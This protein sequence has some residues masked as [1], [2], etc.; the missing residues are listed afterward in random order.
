MELYHAA[1][2][3]CLRLYVANGGDAK[4]KWNIRPYPGTAAI[5]CH[6]PP[7]APPVFTLCMPSFPLNVRL[8]RWKS[9]LVAAYTVH[10]LLH[11]LWTDWGAV[12]QSTV[13]GLHG[14]TNALE[15]N[16]I[17]AR[18]SKGD[19]L[20]VS[21]A[22]KL[23]V[24]LNA[25]IAKRALSSTG[26]ALD[27]ASQFSFVLGLVIF[28]EKLAYPSELPVDWRARVKPEW[29]PLFDLAL[30]RFDALAST[31]DT[32]QLARDLKALA[33][34]LAKPAPKP[35]P[36][37]PPSNPVRLKIVST[38]SSESEGSM[39]HER[40]IVENED[41]APEPVTVAKPAPAGDAPKDAQKPAD[42]QDAPDAGEDSDDGED[43][44]TGEKDGLRGEDKDGFDA[45]DAPKPAKPE[46]A[47]PEP[48]TSDKPAGEPH[49]GAGDSAAQQDGPGGY[50]TGDVQEPVMP[51]PVEPAEDV[52]D[53]TQSYQEANLDD[54][55]RDAAK[56]AGL[57]EH[58]VQREAVQAST[59]L[60]VDAPRDLEVK[61]GGNPRRVGAAIASPAKLRR[62]LTL[63][64]KSPERV[65]VER[66]QV[67]GRLDMRNLVGIMTGSPTI[68]RRRIEEEGREAAVTLLLDISGS[69]A[70]GRLEAAKAL[71]LHMG[72]ALKAAGVRFEIAAFDD[73]F[74][75]TP[76]PFAKGWAN[77]T[78]RAVAGLSTLSGTGMLPAM[79]ACAERLLK[80]GNVSRRIL[81]ALTD[82]Q[83]SF[84][85][86]ANATLCRWYRQRGV[87]IVGIGLM[88]HGVQDNFDG[89]AVSV[90]DCASLSSA[91][92]SQL[93][94]VLDQA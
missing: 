84:D 91:G 5:A 29:L 28:A 88:T 22:R 59:V 12:R 31:W 77:E 14:L 26:Y 74:L 35:A 39:P 75:V 80:V 1:R 30:S 73:R 70:G 89:R 79:K 2:E 83:D 33:A 9:D 43:A 32:L 67:S 90:W 87:E 54:L 42:G 10:E 56:E 36:V 37:A 50:R 49:E 47:K 38:P 48:A 66:R 41:D 20:Q 78:Q 63:A 82:G 17:E 15:D 51:E 60:N 58:A 46:P 8:P 68:F 16:R 86:G 27:D 55:A 25:H 94:K 45:G 92:L 11:A 65:G 18:A 21:E 53:A 24:A 61:R 69:M 7:Y 85:A 57:S 6:R 93:V 62:H 81:I 13:D 4:A 3:T 72:D 23:L 71:A 34:T 52:T 76:K 64:V 19:L 40:E 44:P